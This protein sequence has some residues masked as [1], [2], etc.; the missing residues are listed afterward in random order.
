M[1]AYL[2]L[3]LLLQLLLLLLLLSVC[4]GTGS[5]TAVWVGKAHRLARGHLIYGLG[6]V[7]LSAVGI[8]T[9]GRILITSLLMMIVG[10]LV[11]ELAMLR[12]GTGRL[13]LL[14]AGSGDGCWRAGA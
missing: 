2:S 12:P 9:L 6:P 14:L 3:L 11:R 1:G 10:A 4:C 5:R 7:L 8:V 13:L